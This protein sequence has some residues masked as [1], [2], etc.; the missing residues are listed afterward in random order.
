MNKFAARILGLISILIISY[1]SVALVANIAQ[2]ANAADRIYLGSV[3]YTHLDVYKR[4]R[5][6]FP[7]QSAEWRCSPPVRFRRLG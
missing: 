3:S 2:L 5:Y 6:D 4:Q 1:L 7:H